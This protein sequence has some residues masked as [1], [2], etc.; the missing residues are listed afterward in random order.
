MAREA[1]AAFGGI[2]ILVNNAALMLELGSLHVA[3]VI[4][5]RGRSCCRSM[6]PARSIA[7]RR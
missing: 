4:W 2:E 5:E 6:S 3:D 1:I 7:G